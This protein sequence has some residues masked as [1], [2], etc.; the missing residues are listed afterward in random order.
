MRFRGREQLVSH[1]GKA[2]HRS[3]SQCCSTL[4]SNNLFVSPSAIWPRRYCKSTICSLSFGSV[5][6]ATKLWPEVFNTPEASARRDELVEKMRVVRPVVETGRVLTSSLQDAAKLFLLVMEAKH[7]QASR[8][9]VKEISRPCKL[10]T[11]VA[12]FTWVLTL[13]EQG[14]AFVKG[15]RLQA[16]HYRK[17]VFRTAMFAY[18]AVCTRSAGT[19]T[20]C[21][22]VACWRVWPLRRF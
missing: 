16:M 2:R 4:R 13:P 14:Q 20:W 3:S 11:L 19:R 18:W 12:G 7:V 17:W 8:L 10:T 22:Y 21:R 15:G 9:S 6:A 1:Q 5:Q